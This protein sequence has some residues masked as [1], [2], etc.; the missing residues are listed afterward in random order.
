MTTY[1]DP[2]GKE[3][4]E[5]ELEAQ[6]LDSLNADDLVTVYGFVFYPGDVLKANDPT[7]YR[8][9]FLDYINS[10]ELDGWSEK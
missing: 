4:S 5:N 7:A 6:F 3:V 9:M 8:E 10:L 1:I 2:D